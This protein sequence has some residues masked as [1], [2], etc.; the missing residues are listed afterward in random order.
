MLTEFKKEKDNI[1]QMQ[2]CVYE[3]DST[4]KEHKL[5]FYTEMMDSDLGVA[6]FE[7]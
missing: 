1:L 3:N 5:T 6:P 4:N 2:F 7:K